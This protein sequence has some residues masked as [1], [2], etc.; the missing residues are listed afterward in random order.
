MLLRNVGRQDE[1]SQKVLHLSELFGAKMIE[2]V[3][4]VNARHCETPMMRFEHREILQCTNDQ[5]IEKKR[6]IFLTTI[7]RLKFLLDFI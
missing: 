7:K 2:N 4:L 6:K 5:E 3:R 1:R